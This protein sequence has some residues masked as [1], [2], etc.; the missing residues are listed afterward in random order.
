PAVSPSVQTR[1]TSATASSENSSGSWQ[2][3]LK[4]RARYLILL[5]QLN[6]V[7][8][9]IGAIIL[10]LL[11]LLLMF[12]RRR[13]KATRRVR[14]TPELKQSRPEAITATPAARAATVPDTAA[15][16]AAVA[17]ATSPAR[18]QESDGAH[19][20]RVTAVAEQVKNVV[21]GGDYDESVI[22]SGD[23]ETRQL[24]GAE[25]L[26]ALVGRNIQR[27][28]RARAAFMNHGYFDDATR[29]LRTA[30]APV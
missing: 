13:L 30:E 14:V 20:A 28:E 10:A 11:I 24:V 2:S 12:Q 19:H 21:A 6:P 25:L 26:S 16:T 7:P 27:R 8:V 15:T 23:R 4:E 3:R 17:A 1:P 29:D 9:I 5:A 18:V 22:G